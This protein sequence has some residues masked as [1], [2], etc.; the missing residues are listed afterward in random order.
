MLGHVLRGD[1]DTPA[2]LST[3]FAIENLNNYPCRLGRPIT[4]ILDVIRRDL[5]LRNIDNKLITL[6]DLH[7]REVL[8]LNRKIWKELE[9]IL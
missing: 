9:S 5:H 8:A 4:N 6:L 2:F 7:D 3:C 1:K